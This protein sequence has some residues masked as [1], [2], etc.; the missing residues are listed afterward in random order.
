MADREPQQGVADAAGVTAGARQ[1]KAA[2]GHRGFEDPGVEACRPSERAR[3]AG[4]THCGNAEGGE[5][6]RVPKAQVKAGGTV[7]A[8]GSQIPRGVRTRCSSGS[9]RHIWPTGDP[10]RVCSLMPGPLPGEEPASGRG[11][12]GGL[13]RRDSSHQD[14]ER[15][16]RRIVVSAGRQAECQ[17]QL[18][19]HPVMPI[20]EAVVPVDSGP[21][22]VPH[23]PG[24]SRVRAASWPSGPHRCDLPHPPTPRA[25]ANL[26]SRPARTG[27]L[28]AADPQRGRFVDT[29]SPRAG[30]CCLRFR[31]ESI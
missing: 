9:F 17:V 6:E 26:T 22:P 2:G 31:C 3:A 27:R 28:A 10:R 24:L 21:D 13:A 7:L 8:P 23:L 14:L 29:P 19:H 30:W 16:A 4:M 25:T 20:Y 1:G 11:D 5:Y 15:S 18:E 12:S